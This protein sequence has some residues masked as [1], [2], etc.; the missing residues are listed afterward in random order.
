MCLIPGSSIGKPPSHVLQYRFINK[1]DV[2]NP[3]VCCV[4]SPKGYFR[5]LEGADGIYY[6]P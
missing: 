6:L 3:C 1:T 5:R 4:F 2:L